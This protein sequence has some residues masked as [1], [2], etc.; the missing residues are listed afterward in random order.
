MEK[1]HKNNLTI[2]A[3]AVVLMSILT[4]I[5]F[6]SSLQG[7]GASLI[8]V[9][10]GL[11][12]GFGSKYM[13]TDMGKALIIVLTPAIGTIIYSLAVNGNSVAFLANFILLGMITLYFEPRYIQYFAVP[14][15]IIGLIFSVVRYQVITGVNGSVA[16]SIVI[17]VIFSLNAYCLYCATK[18][19]RALVIKSED[20]LKQVEDGKVV[21]IGVARELNDSI[22]SCE[23]EMDELASQATTVREAAEEMGIVVESNTKATVNVNDQVTSANEQIEKNYELAKKLEESFG[24]ISKAIKSGN[25]EANDVKVSMEEMSKTVSSA[26]EATNALLNEMSKITDILGEINSIANQTN[27]LSLNASIEAARAGEHGKGFAVVAE[28]IRELSVQSKGASDNIASILNG[29]ADTTKEVS[30]K[31]SAGAEAALGAV[32]KLMELVNVFINIEDTT[33]EAHDVVRE[34]YDIIEVVKKD[35]DGIHQDVETLVAASEENAATITNIIESIRN[36][37]DSVK[38][39]KDEMVGISEQSDKLQKQFES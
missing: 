1:L 2:I 26:Q 36:Q 14:V 30:G 12:A 29:L 16:A 18:R 21:T 4:M 32:D 19:G 8:M 35:F 23:N 33:D 13:K 27:L 22:L 34:T 9:A 20:A 15:A 38:N 28:E 24:S 10:C 17:V 6:K 3:V 11:I 7:V 31:I 39:I 25:N 5:N 37:N